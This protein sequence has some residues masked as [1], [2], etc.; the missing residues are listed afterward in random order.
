[1]SIADELAEFYVHTVTVDTYKGSGP[2][3]DA[4]DPTSEPIPCFIDESRR[5]V[6]STNGE[7]IVSET[8][9]WMDKEH[10]EAF[11]PD[12]IVQVNGHESTVITR[13]LADSGDLDLPDH[14]SVNLT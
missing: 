13:S 12:S 3:G 11:K 6:R 2:Y 9:L 4:Y 14:L 1:M 8:T 10:Y 7:Q 5:L